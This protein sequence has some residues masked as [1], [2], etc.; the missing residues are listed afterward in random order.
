MPRKKANPSPAEKT[1]AFNAQKPLRRTMDKSTRTGLGAILK[2]LTADTDRSASKGV[3]LPAS[4]LVDLGF[5][6]TRAW[7]FESEHGSKI[8]C[9][10]NFASNDD[11]TV[12]CGRVDKNH[13]AHEASYDDTFLFSLPWSKEREKLVKALRAELRL[14]SAI[15]PCAIEEIET[16][17]ANPFYNLTVY[18]A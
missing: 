11:F 3:W 14:S 10:I 2:R 18:R 7:S 12:A 15:G 13:P 16:G 5:Y 4:A 17:Q 8:G 9:Q 6:I 1:T